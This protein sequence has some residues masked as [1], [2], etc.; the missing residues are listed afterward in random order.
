MKLVVRA[1]RPMA[2]WLSGLLVIA[3]G[4]YARAEE[5]PKELL[6]QCEGAFKSMTASEGK[7]DFREGPFKI[8]LRLRDGE[9]GNIEYTFL[10]G[11]ECALKDGK[12]RCK[13]DATT[14]DPEL[15][16]TTIEHR[17]VSIN[18]ATGELGLFLETSDFKGKRVTG[19]PW[20]TSRLSR[21]GVCRPASR[22]SL[23]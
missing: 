7:P 19:T 12:I 16:V 23:F 20:M 8:I 4:G 18:R 2:M 14:Y 3:G 11:R 9:I 6:L 5:L 10:E 21:V 13:L 1:K 17:S 15:N 22:G